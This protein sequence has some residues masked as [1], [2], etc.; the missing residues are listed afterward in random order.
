MYGRKIL[1]DDSRKVLS[2][3]LH[4][5]YSQQRL[6]TASGT[7]TTQPLY[8]SIEQ[9]YCSL[10]CYALTSCLLYY[11]ATGTSL[12]VGLHQDTSHFQSTPITHAW[13]GRVIPILGIAYVNA[14]ISGP[15][16]ILVHASTRIYA[17]SGGKMLSMWKFWV[18]CM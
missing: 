8:T 12:L 7:T 4:N 18:C 13:V 14:V 6:K 16:I 11:L 5:V 9:S 15:H 17:I 10:M 3:N 2:E 1:S